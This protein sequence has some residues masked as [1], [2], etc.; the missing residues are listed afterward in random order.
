M[1]NMAT[2]AMSA[3]SKTDVI[4]SEADLAALRERKQHNGEE[5]NLTAQVPIAF[6]G[7]GGPDAG[8]RASR[9]YARPGC[10]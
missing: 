3:I 9:G 1:P 8:G 10:G 5:A 4:A 6:I 2:S 7:R